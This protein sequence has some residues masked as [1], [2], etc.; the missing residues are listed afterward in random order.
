MS[1]DHS[2][3]ELIKALEF[4][5]DM[6]ETLCPDTAGTPAAIHG[7]EVLSRKDEDEEE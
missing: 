3:Q 1:E 5:C 4:C 2:K 6:L 7:R